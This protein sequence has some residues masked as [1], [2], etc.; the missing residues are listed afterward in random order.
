MV[1]SLRGLAWMFRVVASGVTDE[2]ESET[3]ASSTPSQTEPVVLLYKDL[4]AEVKFWELAKRKKNPPV[5]SIL[6]FL[7][8][9]LLF[10]P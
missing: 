10:Y 8:F 3:T 5:R 9:W 2:N 7:V 4:V 6:S 1:T